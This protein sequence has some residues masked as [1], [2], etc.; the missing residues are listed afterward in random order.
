MFYKT[1]VMAWVVAAGAVVL[2]L[3]LLKAIVDSDSKIY[4]CPYCNLV[5]QRNTKRC[6]RCG[7]YISWSGV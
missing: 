2:G 6:P 7:N 5:V 3:A 1:C 4:R